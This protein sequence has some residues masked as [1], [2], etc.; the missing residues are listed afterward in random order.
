MT[1]DPDQALA[2]AGALARGRGSE[3]AIFPGHAPMLC[4]SFIDLPWMLSETAPW[5]LLTSGACLTSRL[6]VQGGRDIRA[7]AVPAR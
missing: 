4:E 3:I 5:P 6:L 2:L 7:Q 1:R